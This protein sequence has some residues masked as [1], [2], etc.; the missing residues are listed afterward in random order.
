MK[1]YLCDEESVATWEDEDA[2]LVPLCQFHLSEFD[3]D[4]GLLAEKIEAMRTKH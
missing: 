2:G 4:A 3:K 1:C